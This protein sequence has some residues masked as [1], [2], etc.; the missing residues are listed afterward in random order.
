[1]NLPN[2][3]TLFR[4]A[5]VPVFLVLWWTH[6]YISAT[7]VFFIASVTDILDGYLA[8]SR[9]QKTKLGALLDPLVDKILVTT[10]LIMLVEMNKIPGWAVVLIISREFLVTG[11]RLILIDHGIVL[12]AGVLGKLKT[13]LQVSAITIL[14]LALSL[15][16]HHS[17][18]ESL[19]M[20]LGT[21]LFW[22]SFVITIASGIQYALKGKMLLQP[23]KNIVIIPKYEPSLAP[24]KDLLI[25][26]TPTQ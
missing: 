23:K 6:F 11:L 25:E 7:A 3:I 24:K 14:Y 16:Q 13:F 17:D 9:N 5:L 4:L 10:G 12:S 19:A 22:T 18:Y 1:M 20:L 21:A 8:R 2:L 26:K 15:K